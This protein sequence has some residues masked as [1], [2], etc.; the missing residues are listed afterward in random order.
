MNR[1]ITKIKES[2]SFN[3][4]TALSL[5]GW[6]E[7]N[8]DTEKKYPIKWFL[9]ETIPDMFNCKIWWPITRIV[10]DKW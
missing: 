7:W 4:P 8:E 5:E 9:F 1:L 3:R 10:V 2:I 6:D